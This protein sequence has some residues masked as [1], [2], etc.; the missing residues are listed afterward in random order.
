MIQNHVTVLPF[1]PSSHAYGVADI[2]GGKDEPFVVQFVRSRNKTARL[3]VATGLHLGRSIEDC[4]RFGQA[5]SAQNAMGLG[6][7]AVVSSLEG[8][9]AFMENT[10]TRG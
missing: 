2:T 3:A 1:L 8:T 5:S 10:P 7:Q 6:S 4:I 9:L